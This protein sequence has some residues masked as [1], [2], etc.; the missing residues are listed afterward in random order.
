M[1]GRPRAGLGNLTVHPD[2][3]KTE[4]TEEKDLDLL[5]ETMITKLLT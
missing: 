1:D 4:Q 5:H 2:S 3:Y